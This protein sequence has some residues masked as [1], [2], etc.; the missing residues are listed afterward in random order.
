M[1]LRTLVLTL[2]LLGIHGAHFVDA[3]STGITGRTNGCSCHSGGANSFTPAI[4]GLPSGGYTGGTTYSLTWDNGGVYISGIGGFNLIATDTSGQAIMG[5]WSNLGFNVQQSGS[6]LTHSAKTSRSWGADWTAPPS[7]SGT[8]QFAIAVLFGNGGQ[9][10][11]NQGDSWGT[12]TITLAEAAG[13]T[14]TP[15]VA[16]N[17]QLSPT[18]PTTLTGL[19]LTYTFSDADGDQESGTEIRWYNQ[20]ALY[21][22]VNDQM[23][24][25]VAKGEQWSVEVTPSDGTDFGTMESAGPVTVLNAPPQAQSCLLYTSDA[26]DE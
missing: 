24:I 9:P 19:T 6:E 22:P 10:A 13:A 23:S 7:G 1:R 16:S 2:L 17:L 3:N 11:T 21:S 25:S 12:N 8:V 20:G 26:A 5:S 14:N 18:N 15:P 4:Y